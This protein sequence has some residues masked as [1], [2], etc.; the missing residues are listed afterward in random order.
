M[1]AQT[2]DPMDRLPTGL[3]LFV[4]NLQ[5]L[6]PVKLDDTNY[7]SW[8]AT[9]RAN[10]VAHRLLEYVDGSEVPPSPL[11]LDE[12]A[13]APGKDAPPV[14][15]PN[16]AYDSWVLVD[17]QVRACLIAIVSPTV[18]THIHALPSSAAIWNH[19]EQRYNSLSRT[20]IF[21]LK[22]RLHSIQKGTDSMQTYLD[23]VL[24]IVSSLKLAHE[25]IS[26]QDII[27]C[28]RSIVLSYC[29]AS[30][31]MDSDPAKHPQL[32]PPGRRGAAQLGSYRRALKKGLQVGSDGQESIDGAREGEAAGGVL[33]AELLLGAAQQFLEH[34]MAEGDSSVLLRITYAVGSIL[35][36]VEINDESSFQF[37]MDL[38]SIDHDFSKLPICVEFVH[39]TTPVQAP[40]PLCHDNACHALMENLS[41]LPI[42]FSDTV[43]CSPYSSRDYSDHGSAQGSEVIQ[44]EDPVPFH[45]ATDQQ[46]LNTMQ[47]YNACAEPKINVEVIL[48]YHPTFICK[49]MIYKSKLDL[50]HH[51]QM[52]SI[53]NNFQYRTLTSNKKFLHVVCLDDHCAWTVRAVRLERSNLFQIRRFDSSHSC[54]V[55]LREGDHRQATSRLLSDLVL[56]RYTDAFKKPYGPNDI[57]EDMRR[58][59]DGTFLKAYFRGTLLTACTQDANRQIVPLAFGICDTASK[60]TW[61]WFLTNVKRALTERSNLYIIS[62]RHDGIIYAVEQVFPSVSHG[63]CSEHILRNIKSKFRGKSEV[64]QWKFRG[65]AQAA[66][67]KEFEE[68]LQLLDDEDPRIREYLNKIG[69]SK[70]SRCHSDKSRYSSMTSNLAESLN[71]VNNSAREFPVAKLVEFIR[72][73]M[74]LWFHERSEIASSTR[75]PLPKKLEVV[76]IQMQREAF[77]MK[78]CFSETS[79]SYI[80]AYGE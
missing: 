58:D 11:I 16:P 72:D 18:Q 56:H 75:T 37:Y 61:M 49:N 55:D 47:S 66:T 30:V 2:S 48:H 22:E 70:W 29:R 10:L 63:Y 41:H 51:L 7:P 80:I 8:S 5:S 54:S 45:I 64:I 36:P 35:P 24:T 43:S 4:R 15:K 42:S 32:R 71:N 31:M 27:L 1:A 34:G 52:Y 9:V 50:Q 74:Q 26:E 38:K 67:V 57:R 59:Y 28:I 21:Q 6:T 25:D 20:H 39:T 76:L 44:M 65:A 73:R 17:A 60:E 14:M 68:Y 33:E 79:H 53:L 77:R 19:L 23:T 40:L 3:K 78:V 12:K 13:A 46:D 69:N 62:N